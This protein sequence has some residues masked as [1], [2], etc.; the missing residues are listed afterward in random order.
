MDERECRICGMPIDDLENGTAEEERAYDAELCLQDA[1]N[2]L[3][4]M[5]EDDVAQP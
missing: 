3:G 1:E 4:P 5:P 2:E